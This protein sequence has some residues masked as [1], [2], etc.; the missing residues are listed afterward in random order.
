MRI[1]SPNQHLKLLCLALALALMVTWALPPVSAAAQKKSG[2]RNTAAK[3]NNSSKVAQKPLPWPQNLLALV[4][5]GAVLV[6]DHRGPLDPPKELYAHNAEKFYVPA[7]IVKIITTGAALEFLG[8]DYRFRTEFLLTR[9][10]DL[11]I[12][13]Y[14]D[15]YLV[16][17]ELV[18]IVQALQK[19]GLKEVRNLYL[20]TSYFEKDLILDGNTQTMSPYDAYNLAFGVNFN[21]ITFRKNKKGQILRAA[22]NIPLTPLAMAMAAKTKGQG[23][24]RLNIHESP[25]LAEVH[26]AQMFKCHLEDAGIAVKGEILTGQ[27]APERRR[28]YY[29]HESSKTLETVLRD[30]MKYSNNFM[31]NQVFLTIGA[32]LYGAPA[33][34]EKSQKAME[35]YFNRHSLPTIVMS[36]GSGLSRRTS[37]TARQMAAVLKVVQDNRHLFTSREDGQVFCKTGTM[38]DIKTLAGYLE[39]PNDPDRPLSFVILLNG[40]NYPPKVRDNILEILRTQFIPQTAPAPALTPSAGR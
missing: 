25:A 40:T 34:L 23:T 15:P 10:G 3:K 21:T 2:A 26:A 8:P 22:E 37:L 28:I 12:I 27:V 4:G 24:F 36:D 33:T 38:S 30:L 18:T 16:S 20:D 39:R 11:W 5:A 9:D 31:T 13:G 32:E 35:A 14:G 17:E 6:V 19:R 29:R 7:S 1:G